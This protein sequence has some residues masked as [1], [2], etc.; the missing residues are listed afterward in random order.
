VR[1]RRLRLE[2]ATYFFTVVTHARR[3]LFQEAEVVGWLEAAIE[4]VRA[5]HPFEIE[6]Q[7]ILPDHLHALWTLPDDDANYSSRWRLIK[8]A[9]TRKFLQQRRGP[10]R[11]EVA[12][13]RGEQPIW[14]RR[15]WEH[16]IRD[17]RDF[18]DHVDYIHI[19]PLRHG[20][21]AA[22]GQWP[23]STFK[24]WLDLGCYEPTWGTDA[25]PDL[26]DWKKREL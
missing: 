23:H 13:K 17:E 20:L 7:V 9:F 14:Q 8:E 5:R 24:A 11:T 18:Q 1:Y 4:A 6:A 2:G 22:P 15:F 3:P 19:N 25:M 21:A 16:T 10:P 26:S 12:R